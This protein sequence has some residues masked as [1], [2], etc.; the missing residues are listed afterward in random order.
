MISTD[1]PTFLA[2]NIIL[3]L[4]IAA[5][6]IGMYGGLIPIFSVKGGRDHR[7]W[8]LLFTRAMS[9]AALTAFPLA[10]WRHDLFQG[11]IGLFSGYLAVFGFRVLRRNKTKAT[12][13]SGAIFDWILATV[14]LSMFLILFA[15]GV[16]FTR[17]GSHETGAIGIGAT[18]I[19]AAEIA[20]TGRAA[21]IFGAIG[22]LVAARDLQSLISGDTSR[23][24]RIFDHLISSSLSLITA[25]SAFLN[26]QFHRI[27]G[28]D[29]PIDQ[30]MLL[31]LAIGLPL[32][33]YTSLVWYQLLKQESPQKF[34]SNQN[35][36]AS[37]VPSEL[38]RIRVFALAEG[39]SFL[40]LLFVAVPLKRIGGDDA[41]VRLLG[42]VHGGLFVLYVLSVLMAIPTLRWGPVRIAVALAAAALPFGTFLLDAKLR[43]EHSTKH[44]AN[45]NGQL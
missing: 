33:G 36:P 41:W 43:R 9:V 5:G 39:I 40:L 34:M 11:A 13:S 24:R 16:H 27:T 1:R 26:T 12:G 20:A 31:P 25:F 21:L 35:T 14:S 8:G 45:S 30:K 6:F 44:N 7:Q 19:E 15:L 2:Y 23:A 32:L 4:H 29:W 10:Y 22:I 18:E 28:L 17:T 42:P 38:K 37:P 3:G